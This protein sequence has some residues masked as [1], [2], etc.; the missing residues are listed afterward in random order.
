MSES[1]T[2]ATSSLYV[3]GDQPNLHTK[4]LTS[5]THAVIFDLEDAVTWPA[6]ETALHAVCRTLL[7]GVSDTQVWVRIEPSL[8]ESQ[9]KTLPLPAVTGIV[10]PKATWTSMDEVAALLEDQ[11]RRA[12]LPVGSV[13]L[14]ALLETAEGI[15]DVRRI[16][17][18]PRARRLGIGEVDL[19]ADLGVGP[20]GPGVDPWTTIRIQLV[21][22]AAAAGIPGPIAPVHRNVTDLDGLRTSSRAFA[23]L[24]FRA[25]TVLSPR[26]IDVVNLSFR[27]EP[28]T[29]AWALAVMQS[30]GAAPERG[31]AMTPD[32]E[33]VDIA[34]V[35]QAARLLGVSVPDPSG[36]AP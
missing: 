35:R 19:A 11:E 23:A 33:M 28:S 15:L 14:I 36:G 13:G 5:D 2:P 25:R 24:G 29:E 7:G 26:Q 18:H 30:F 8:R 22:A 4:A 1:H 31:V 34:T 9:I 20:S 32:G 3:P 10:V 12:G 16:A 6:K 27:P 17:R 21:L